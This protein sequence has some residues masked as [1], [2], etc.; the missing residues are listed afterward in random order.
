VAQGG[1]ERLTMP[2]GRLRR[3]DFLKNGD[4]SHILRVVSSFVSLFRVSK[5]V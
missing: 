2:L 5:G 4:H 3:R 1:L